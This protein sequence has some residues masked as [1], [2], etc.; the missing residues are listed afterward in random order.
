MSQVVLVLKVSGWELGTKIWGVGLNSDNQVTKVVVAGR[1]AVGRLEGVTLAASDRPDDFRFEQTSVTIGNYLL[2]RISV[3][4]ARI[5]RPYTAE[6]SGQLRFTF[7]LKGSM[8]ITQAGRRVLLN[9]GDGAVS[10]GWQSYL[11]VIPEETTV[12]RVTIEREILDSKGILFSAFRAKT[13]AAL[14]LVEWVS[15]VLQ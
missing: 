8:T 5:E 2:R 12:V 11:S 7:V 6:S 14:D 3:T 10:I 13:I 15:R 1:E 4:P 9:P